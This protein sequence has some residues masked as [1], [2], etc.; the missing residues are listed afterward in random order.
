MIEG[1]FFLTEGFWKLLDGPDRSPRNVRDVLALS[2][3]TLNPKPLVL[4]LPSALG[5]AFLHL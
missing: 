5:F 2:P 4:P 1:V 3:L